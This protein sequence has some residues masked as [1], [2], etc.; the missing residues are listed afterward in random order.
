MSILAANSVDATI[1]SHITP[2]QGPIS[3]PDNGVDKKA[4]VWYSR[5]DHV[6]AGAS[7][8]NYS[9]VPSDR[10]RSS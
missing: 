9:T 8:P 6:E 4:E 5:P 3:P 10:N 1:Y 7:V 2:H